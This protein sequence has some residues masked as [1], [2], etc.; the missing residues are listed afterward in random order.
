[1]ARAACPRL[2]VYDEHGN[3]EETI[4]NIQRTPIGPTPIVLNPSKR[5]GFVPAVVGPE[6]EFL[7]LQSFSY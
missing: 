7:E 1:L 5:I 6:N 2:S 4:S 3:V